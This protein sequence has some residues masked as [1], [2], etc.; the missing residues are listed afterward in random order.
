[1]NCPKFN[2]QPII[3]FTINAF[4][5]ACSALFVSDLARSSTNDCNSNDRNDDD[6]NDE[7]TPSRKRRKSAS[8]TSKTKTKNN[9]K[10]QTSHAKNENDTIPPYPIDLDHVK[11]QIQQR[12]ELSFLEGVLD[13]LTEANAPKYDTAARK[14]RRDKDNSKLRK[15]TTTSTSL[16]SAVAV[17]ATTKA[18]KTT[19][20][21]KTTSTALLKNLPVAGM[22]G[23]NEKG[24]G[25]D[26]AVL[27]VAI[28]DAQ[29]ESFAKMKEIIADDDDYD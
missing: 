20:R 18:A 19:G 13:N 8:T 5:G 28:Q 10:K 3:I 6:E 16:T 7:S 27:N 29:L 15:A 23:S 17:A 4:T 11:K 24:L 12:P 9:T 2:C 26:E 1:M 22:A 25:E 21:D 14:R